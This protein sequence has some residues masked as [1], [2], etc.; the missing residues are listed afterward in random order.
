MQEL[1]NTNIENVKTIETENKPNKKE[2][3]TNNIW[4]YPYIIDT[5][6]P[7]KTSVTKLKQANIDTINSQINLAK[8]EFL[9]E[10]EQIKL[11]SA[12][13]GTL[14]HL[15]MQH[16]NEKEEY[17]INKVKE[18]INSLKLKG[19]IT[20]IEAQNINPNS[21]L[22]FTRSEIFEQLKQAKE[23]NKEKPFYITIPA[24]Q[25]DEKYSSQ[26][27]LVQGI[28]DLYYTNKENELVLVDYKTDY[29]E[30]GN[31]EELISK[32]KTQLDLY[33]RAL[34]EALRRKVDKTYI[35][36]VYLGKILKIG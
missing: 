29:I 28:I 36:S 4:E 31:E 22:E 6:I 21:I 8:P 17:D 2:E 18:L 20:D 1:K 23:I 15:C 32:Y 14:I 10:S 24:N 3:E 35:Y 27:V 26:E 9:K 25:I 5:I 7:T 13:K 30:N 19:I 16:L 11:T 33:R 12:Q 34:E